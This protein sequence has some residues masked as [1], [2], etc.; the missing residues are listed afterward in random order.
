M[1]RKGT[2]AQKLRIQ[3]QNAL[4]HPVLDT[5]SYSKLMTKRNYLSTTQINGEQRAMFLEV[6]Q[7]TIQMKA[8]MRKLQKL[9]RLRTKVLVTGTI[10]PNDT[11]KVVLSTSLMYSL[12]KQN[13][14]QGE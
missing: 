13:R 10:V 4:I 14:R 11:T 8:L 5:R 1:K 3:H 7:L 2:R 12:I 6:I 9:I